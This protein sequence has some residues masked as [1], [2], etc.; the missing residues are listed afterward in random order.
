M[1][2]QSRRLLAFVCNSSNIC[3]KD[4][5]VRDTAKESDRERERSDIQIRA[6]IRACDRETYTIC[7]MMYVFSKRATKIEI[8]RESESDTQLLSC[9]LC[10]VTE[11]HI[12]SMY[13]DA[14]VKYRFSFR[15]TPISSC[16]RV[17]PSRT[18]V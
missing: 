5:K 4:G 12:Y 1:V 13:S 17:S 16:V 8:E 15:S 9:N 7:I 6:A 18:P 11:T 3:V 10:N 14:T 2:L